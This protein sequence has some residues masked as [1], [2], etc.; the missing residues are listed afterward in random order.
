MMDFQRLNEAVTPYPELESPSFLQGM[1]IG[2]LCVD[3]DIQESVWIRRILEE[4]QV[5]S[6][7]ESFLIAL[8]EMF[9][10]T[11]KGLNGSGF[12][13]ALCLPDDGDSLVMRAAMLGQLC[14]GLIYGV[15][16]GG[17]LNEMEKTLNESV[18]ELIND[19][20]EIARIDV[21]ALGELEKEADV[22]QIEQDLMELS[23]FV[24]VGILTL[25]EELNPVDAA[26]IMSVPDSEYQL[27]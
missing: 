16:L 21:S 6:V 19:L 14:E 26:P 23:E 22:E 17:G 1:L 12:E 2:L 25:N 9:L 18:R 10:E 24:K 7:K 11:N 15:G 27:H 5:K 3:S 4:A 8:H 13:L 20:S